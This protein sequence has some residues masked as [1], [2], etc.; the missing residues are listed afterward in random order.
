[1]KK[2]FLTLFLSLLT[3]ITYC[4]TLYSFSMG[5]RNNSYENFSWGEIKTLDSPIPIKF[6]GKDIKIYTERL[7]Y[8]QTLLP[9]HKT[10]G[11]HYWLAY[12]ADMKKCKFYMVEYYGK[13][14]ILIEYDDMCL[15][16][17]VIY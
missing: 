1:M 12:D 4:Q 3:T 7:Q 5:I 6:D 16:Y 8:Y 2:L 9:E 15:L 10:E 14:F 17:G 13:D 11:G